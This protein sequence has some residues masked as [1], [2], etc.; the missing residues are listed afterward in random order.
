M[1]ESIH[2]EM[3]KGEIFFTNTNQKGF[4]SMGFKTKRRGVTTYNANGQLFKR[5]DWFPVF[6]SREEL[7]QSN[8]SLKIERRIFQ[9]SQGNY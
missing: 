9:E 1:S 8:P 6:I 4:E 7:N 2:P 3:E 5:E